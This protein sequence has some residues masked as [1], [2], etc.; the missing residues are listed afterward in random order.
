MDQQ[1]GVTLTRILHPCVLFRGGGA[2]I[3]VDPCFGEFARR[4]LTSR[5]TGIRMPRPGIDPA[6]LGGVTVVALTH[7]HEDHLDAKGMERIPARTARVIVPSRSI[8]RR[9]R[10]LGFVRTELLRVWETARGEGWALTALPARAP[11]A[12]IET[13]Y[14]LELGGT[15][16]LH[17]G[18]TASHRHFDEIRERYRPHAGCLPVSGVSILG[19]RLTMTPEQA[20][21]AAMALG[22]KV[23]V[24][25]HAEMEFRGLSALVYRARGTETAFA[26]ACRRI[27]PG[28]QVVIARRGEP[29]A[30]GA[31]P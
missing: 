2:E 14:L 18:D 31:F 19:L 10:R 15:R 25:I 5:V 29:V 9:V 20:A 6:R 21:R 8:E 22:L 17:A 13:S 23:V 1:S 16:I 3:L 4:P 28:T 27:A 7:G 26:E 24:P 30:L 12:R 11:N